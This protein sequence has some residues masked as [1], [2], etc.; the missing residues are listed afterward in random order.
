MGNMSAVFYDGIEEE[1]LDFLEGEEMKTVEEM[2]KV[3][4]MDGKMQK[5]ERTLE[6]ERDLRGYLQIY[7]DT[8]SEEEQSLVFGCVCDVEEELAIQVGL[9]SV[10]ERRLLQEMGRAREEGREIPQ[11]MKIEDSLSSVQSKKT[12]SLLALSDVRGKKAK[13]LFTPE[14]EEKGDGVDLSGLSDESLEALKEM[15]VTEDGFFE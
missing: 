5:E 7:L 13:L 10:R 2:N 9:L 11:R 1:E 3:D 12:R 4:E 15:L 14:V 8:L 6:K